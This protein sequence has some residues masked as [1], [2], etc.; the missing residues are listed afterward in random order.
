M[1]TFKAET[2][3]VLIGHSGVW[4]AKMLAAPATGFFF[5]G[6]VNRRSAK[7]EWMIEIAEAAAAT[8]SG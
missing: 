7:A 2:G 1:F 4:G 5:S 6:T 8:L 3:L